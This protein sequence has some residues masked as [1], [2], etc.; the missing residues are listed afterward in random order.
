MKKLLISVLIAGLPGVALAD[1]K[2]DQIAQLKA[3]LEALQAQMQQLQQAVNAATAAK[4]ADSTAADDANAEMKQRVTSMEMKVDK[5]NTDASE[6]PIAGLSITGYMDPTYLASRVGKSAGFQFVNHSNQYSYTNS[7]FGDVYL[8]IK[9]TFGVGPLA[10][11]AEVTILPN[12]G[13][14]NTLMTSG[15]SSSAG[16]NIINTAVVTFP[17]SD[18][19][20]LVAGLMNSFG[21][22]EVQQS[23]QINTITHGLLYDFSD[24]G[25]Y[26]GAGFNWSHDVWAT[27]FMIANEQFHTNPNSATDANG[28]THSNSTPTVTG[29]VDYTMTSNLDLGGSMNLGRQSLYAHS[30]NDTADGTYGYQGTSNSA[31]SAYYFGEM[32][33]TYTGTDSIYNAEI[34]YGTQKQA[35]W[36]GGDAVW[37]GF[38]LLAHQKWTT[39]TFGRMGATLRYDYLNDSKNG[40]GGGGIALGSGGVDGTDGFGISQ[41]CFN[42]SSVNGTDCSGAT[43]QAITA[44]LL[45][46]PTDQLTL[47]M[48]YRHDWANHDVFLRSDGSYRKSNDIIA[49]QAVYSF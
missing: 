28:N 1:A 47:K 6:G 44:A 18:T 13:S 48:E 3:Q 42:S 12:R 40:G 27:K 33:A 11:S 2:A 25:S 26:V 37:Y 29:R 49:A 10:P 39:E 15:G 45:F 32:D 30:T 20:Q 9:K 19:T 17:L 46:Y 8:D 43:R 4:D 35:A 31:Y 16:N 41:A 7:T 24:P 38:S 21:G 22:Y 34:D 5:L 14:G 36:N 23:N